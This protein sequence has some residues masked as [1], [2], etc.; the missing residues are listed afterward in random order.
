MKNKVILFVISLFLL[1]CSNMYGKNDVTIL[2]LPEKAEKDSVF[3]NNFELQSIIPLQTVQQSI[4]N[5]IDRII[6]KDDYMLIQSKGVYIFD[7]DGKFIRQIGCPGNGPGEYHKIIDAAID[8][9][10]NIVIFSDDYKFIYYS[11]DGKYLR[12]ERIKDKKIFS[13]MLFIKDELYV[14]CGSKYTEKENLIQKYSNNTFSNCGDIIVADFVG[15]R[16]V[17]TFGERF[18]KS[19][20]ILFSQN[21]ENIIYELKNGLPIKRY[22]INTPKLITKKQIKELAQ[23]GN[24]LRIAPDLFST[25]TVLCFTSIRETKDGVFCETNLDSF[26]WIEPNGKCHKFRGIFNDKISYASLRYFAHDGDDDLLVFIAAPEFIVQRKKGDPN[27]P[28]EKILQTVT[29]DD[30]PVL[31]F[32]R[33]KKG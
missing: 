17:Y 11:K 14:Y 27:H 21:T 15:N 32:F 7:R 16:H 26:I 25:Q 8:N 28:T 29:E 19:K 31:L 13:A 30:N 18:V 2:S 3:F 1:N 9:D 22:R 5:R 12:Q 10:N 6:L 23:H 24:A 33:R 4:L 20:S